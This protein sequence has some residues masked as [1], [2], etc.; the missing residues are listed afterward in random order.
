MITLELTGLR[1]FGRH[2]GA[3]R[4]Q[5][6]VRLRVRDLL[7][8]PRDRVVVDRVLEPVGD[9]ALAHVELD[10]EDEVLALLT[11]L[12]IHA[13][14]AEQAQPGELERDHRP[15]TTARATASAST[16]SRTSCT[17]RIVAP[18]S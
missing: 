17:R 18:R 11:L 7:Y 8:G 15:A 13:V 9:A 3:E 16:C 2:G 12:R 10:V 6:A 4:L 5:Q 14:A 1:L